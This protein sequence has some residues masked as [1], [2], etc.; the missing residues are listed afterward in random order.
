M[1]NINLPIDTLGL[2]HQWIPFEAGLL[3]PF[4]QEDKSPDG[5]I[6]A[7]LAKGNFL[8][9]DGKLSEDAKHVFSVIAD[10][11]KTAKLRFLVEGDLLDYQVFF[12]QDNQKTVSLKRGEK[13][14]TLNAPSPSGEIID[15]IA[16]FS[17]MG[18]FGTIPAKWLLSNVE[19][20][21]L[22]AVIDILRRR[23]MLSFANDEENFEAIIAK[24]KVS[25]VV[26][27]EQLNANWLIWAVRSFIPEQISVSGAEIDSALAALA[28]KNLIKVEGE[29]IVPEGLVVF[30]A[31]KLL[32]LNCLYLVDTFNLRGKE[33]PEKA[34]FSVIQNGVRELLLLDTDGKS[35]AWQGISGKALI[36]LLYQNMELINSEADA[37]K[38]SAPKKAKKKPAPA[39]AVR[40]D[41]PSCGKP[42]KKN[43]KFCSKCGKTL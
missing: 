39:K 42:L 24:A 6:E 16:D 29:N 27:K 26:N 10:S 9:Q 15:L 43:A 19:S 38:S 30:T 40:T 1:K 12:S 33:A 18:N 34:R 3:Y 36:S 32:H 2:I 25:E 14:F 37:K 13:G 20:I 17:G 7:M 5:R 31:R 8:T 23:I 21:V 41:C 28:E 22:S 35:I 11:Q 4:P